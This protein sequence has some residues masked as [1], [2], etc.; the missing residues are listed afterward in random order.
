MM[1]L[2]PSQGCVVAIVVVVVVV[3]VVDCVVYAVQ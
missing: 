2:L 3:N 1:K